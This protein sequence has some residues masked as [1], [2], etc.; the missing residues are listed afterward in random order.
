MKSQLKE[1]EIKVR[2]KANNLKDFEEE[3]LEWSNILSKAQRIIE[4]KYE[5]P[6]HF[7]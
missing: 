7:H 4:T 3:H 5:Y 6:K 1:R 2:L